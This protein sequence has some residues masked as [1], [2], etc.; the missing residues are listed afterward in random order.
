MTKRF[1]WL[2]LL[3]YAL[4]FWATFAVMLIMIVR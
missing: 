1:V 2:G 4:I 3:I